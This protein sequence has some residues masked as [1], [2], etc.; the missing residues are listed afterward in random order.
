M[1]GIDGFALAQRLRADRATA[2]TPI[3]FLSARGET[4]DKV[5]A[6]KLGAED[7]MVKPFDAAE[8]VAR[9]E[10]ALA[11]ARRE[12]GASPTTQLPGVD[13]IEAEIER[14]LVVGRR[15]RLL[16]PR[17][18][19]PQG[20]QRLLRLRQ[21]RRRDPPDR[22]RHPRRGRARRR[23]GRLHRPHRRR[24][25]RVRHHR[26]IAPTRCADGDRDLRSPDPAL[27]QQDRPR[28][29]LHRDQRSLRRR[30][31]TSRS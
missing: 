22:R 10:K 13:A 29:R 30:C 14:R 31:A 1:P 3:I 5:R 21:G 20:V 7:Y 4:A 11:P 28:A 8:L 23:A 12:L 9:V 26:A 2:L 17:P 18:R 15:L 24:R 27:L 6:F 19:Q 25:L 16:L